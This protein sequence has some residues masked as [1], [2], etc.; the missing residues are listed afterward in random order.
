MS[1][2]EGQEVLRKRG[3][4]EYAKR[5]GEMTSKVNMGQALPLAHDME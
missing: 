4:T 2:K 3:M 1:N 5:E